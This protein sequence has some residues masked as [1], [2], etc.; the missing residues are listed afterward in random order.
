[1]K[2]ELHQTLFCLGSFI[3]SNSHFT[4]IN[5]TLLNLQVN[6]VDESLEL[7]GIKEYIMKSKSK[8]N[9]DVIHMYVYKDKL[10]K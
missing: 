7:F 8:M 1:M 2:K 10:H 4:F 3:Y 6:W 9:R 5:F